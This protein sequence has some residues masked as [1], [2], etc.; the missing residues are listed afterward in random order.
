MIRNE[1]KPL[2]IISASLMWAVMSLS[3]VA[4]TA[5]RPPNIVIVLA[6]DMGYSDIGCF[7]GEVQT[8]N[9]NALAKEGVRFT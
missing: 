6:D 8:P 1:I 9:L 2:A 7:G 4:A 3:S 5:E